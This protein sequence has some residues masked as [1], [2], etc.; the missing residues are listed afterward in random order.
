[1][2][3]D[4]RH[5]G[6][7]RVDGFEF[8]VYASEGAEERAREIGERA[9]R[10][11]AWLTETFGER[12]DVELFVVG[13]SDWDQVADVPIY[14][15]PQTFGNRLTVSPDPAGF[16]QDAVDLFWPDLSDVT[17][18][19]VHRVYG[20]PPAVGRRFADLVVAHELTHLFHEYD[21]VTQRLDF[22]R[23]WLAEL[24][25]SIGMYGYLATVEPQE[26]PAAATICH[27]AREI[28]PG[29]MPV[30]ALDDM[31]RTFEFGPEYYVIYEFLLLA[32]AER[33]W[34][35][36][37][38]AALRGFHTG[39]R[40]SDLGDEEIL[41]ALERIHPEVGR[42]VRAWPDLVAVMNAT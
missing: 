21:E 40:N 5:H 1:M 3:A 25:A 28:L 11:L 27:A 19:A 16:W 31:E 15:M 22:P 4:D 20:D 6:L 13:Q 24:F 23:L 17:K 14:G 29:R 10:A 36:A 37:G 35:V 26:L 18:D 33:I 2:A 34:N 38:V 39:L 42:L 41:A 8:A 30:T 12:R 7:A 9:S 32:L